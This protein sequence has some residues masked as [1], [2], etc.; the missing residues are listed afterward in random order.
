MVPLVREILVPP[1]TAV[2]TADAPQLADT[3]GAVELLIVTFAGRLSTKEKLVRFESAGAVMVI[4]NLEFSPGWIVAGTK[5]FW[6]PTP[7]PAVYMVTGALAG[8]TFVIPWVVVM[9]PAGIVFVKVSAVAP[10]GAVTWTVIVQV[11]GV[12]GLPAG[13]V[14]PVKVTVRGSVVEAVPPQVVAA[15]PGTTVNTVPGNVSAMFT[16]VRADPVGF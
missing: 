10:R 1:V 9:A 7:A 14:P 12:V 5:L 16:P 13:M 2:R 15:E 3:D 8:S 11:P 4:V 6:A